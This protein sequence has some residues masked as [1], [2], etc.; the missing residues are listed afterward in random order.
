MGVGG[1]KEGCADVRT[2]VSFVKCYGGEGEIF[3]RLI[4]ECLILSQI[5]GVS[6][7]SLV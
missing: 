4:H 2:H 3:G 1:G 6:I 7:A 5:T